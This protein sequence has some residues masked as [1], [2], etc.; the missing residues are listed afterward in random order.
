MERRLKPPLHKAIDF[1]EKNNFAYAVIGGLAISQWGQVRATY[2]VDI[3][4]HVPETN[5]GDIAKAIR[6]AF[7]VPARVN[8][9]ANPLIVSVTIDNVVIDFLLALPG[10]EEQII[11]RAVMRE[12]GGRPVLICSAEDLLIQ[13]VVS[14]RPKDWLDIETIL[15][16]QQGK[17]DEAYVLDWLSQFAQALEEPDIIEKYKALQKKIQD[18]RG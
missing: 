13:K 9:P 14:G 7:P 3:K 5:Y 8:L 17:L 12:L 2:D 16:D 4:V 11:K 6:K 10:Y 15:I 18:L 1:L